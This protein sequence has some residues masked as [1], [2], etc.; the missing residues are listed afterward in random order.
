MK[1]FIMRHKSLISVLAV[2]TLF[3]S[4]LSINTDSFRKND[5]RKII[6]VGSEV[7][8]S[9]T[10]DYTATGTAA[11][12]TNTFQIALNALPTTGG[13]LNILSGTYT[14][15]ATLT[16]AIPNVTIE[17]IGNSTIFSNNGSTPIFAAGST[18]WNIQNL[19]LDAGGVT[20]TWTGSNITIGTQ[21]FAVYGGGT[22]RTA[23][24]VIAASNSSVIDK[25]QADYVM[26]LSTSDFGAVFNAAITAGYRTF[27]LCAGNYAYSTTCVLT[28]YVRFTGAGISST[29][30]TQTSGANVDFMD[31]P[32][33]TAHTQNVQIVDVGCFTVNGNLSN[34]TAGYG[35]RISPYFS[36]LHNMDIHNC[37]NDNLVI[38]YSSAGTD[39]N[40]IRDN[41]LY[42]AGGIGLNIGNNGS[43]GNQFVYDN[44]VFSNL[45]AVQIA[46]NG[47]GNSIHGNHIYGTIP[48][49]SNCIEILNGTGSRIF[50]NSMAAA[51]G[52]NV[53]G[54][55][56]TGSGNYNNIEVSNNQIITFIGTPYAA[57][58]NAPSGGGT[59]YN[60]NF[61]NNYIHVD[62]G[63]T[64]ANGFFLAPLTSGSM[65]GNNFNVAGSISNYVTGSTSG[66]YI[67]NN[68]GFNPVGQFSNAI[69]V[70]TIGLGGA[71]STVTASTD[72]TV[73]DVDC[74]INTTNSSNTNCTVT[75]KDSGGNTIQTL[76]GATL[77]TYR[78]FLPIGYKINWGAFTGTAPTVTVFGN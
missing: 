49:W 56:L 61:A 73:I 37:Y 18:G 74:F 10:A 36:C 71:G 39:D 59:G 68:P 27:Y 26:P 66:Y 2:V 8:A 20:G 38:E 1:N 69:G 28:D 64:L 75:I 30:F 32:S 25:A 9:T 43:V 7:S 58:I 54:I 76:T 60:C 72:Y 40:T 62:G 42:S 67:R 21:Y 6:T 55:N 52:A 23:S 13:I 16:R 29:L 12:Q 41:Y 14:L 51:N 63:S 47:N 65:T 4:L 34:V 57:F 31:S 22:G 11:Q 46:A 35:I 3:G 70:G 19:V 48:A 45:G 50:D 5:I 24:Y 78:I 77:P 44:Q 53:I 17:G 33:I 15:N